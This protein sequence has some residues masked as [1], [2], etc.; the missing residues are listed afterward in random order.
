MELMKDKDTYRFTKLQV[1][2]EYKRH[3]EVNPKGNTVGNGYSDVVYDIVVVLMNYLVS[4]YW[5]STT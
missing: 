3:I 5:F 4:W 2:K 1:N